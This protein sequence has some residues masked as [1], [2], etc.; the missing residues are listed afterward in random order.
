MSITDTIQVNTAGT[1]GSRVT[2][3]SVEVG[4][5]R[6]A[7][8]VSLPAST[9]NQSQ[10]MAFTVASLQSVY[11]LSSQNLTIKT[12]SSGSPANTI[13]LKAGIPYIW[14]ASAGYNTCLF[15]VDV[16]S[17]FLTCTAAARLQ[18]AILTS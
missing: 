13:N 10:A 5:A 14:R 16:T 12:N 18:A 17:W 7:V 2:G 3:S 11:L 1:D 4:N 8:D 6:L 15:T 9:T